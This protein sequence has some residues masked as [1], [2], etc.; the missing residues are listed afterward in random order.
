[1]CRWNLLSA[2]PL[3]FISLFLLSGCTDSIKI[4][5]E[6]LDANYVI[7]SDGESTRVSA[8]FKEKNDLSL[9]ISP[10]EKFFATTKGERKEMTRDQTPI[11]FDFSGLS[12]IYT[13][14]LLNLKDS[15]STKFEGDYQG[16]ELTLEMTRSGKQTSST[17]DVTLP[18]A[19]DFQSPNG[20]DTFNPGDT[21]NITWS[22]A[23]LSE[24]VGLHF[25]SECDIS[26]LFYTSSASG[27]FPLF[28]FFLL[29]FR[30]F[31]VWVDDT[32]SFD[33]SGEDAIDLG[34][35]L[36]ENVEKDETGSVM[37]ISI[38][39]LDCQVSVYLKRNE[40]INNSDIFHSEKIY[41][42][43]YRK[44]P[45]GIRVFAENGWSINRD[46][47]FS[48]LSPPKE[49]ETPEE[50]PENEAPEE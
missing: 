44:L 22:P 41:L 24:K 42:E 11:V 25:V 2:F 8:S 7:Y 5:T 30:S 15:F 48:S 27:E 33:L 10:E 31:E 3:L 28:P 40:T 21:I 46:Y 23:G 39:T 4:E 43:T 36:A 35:Y 37:Y 29:N 20:G 12:L 50:I 18:P 45:S 47:D 9:K 38:P 34:K 13:S 49:E 17:T 6:N 26:S 16:E 14:P 19:S 1:M 32:G